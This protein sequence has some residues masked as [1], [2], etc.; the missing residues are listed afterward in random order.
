MTHDYYITS[1][2]HCTCGVYTNPYN[3]YDVGYKAVGG[4]YAEADN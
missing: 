4:A 3:V 1:R 2:L